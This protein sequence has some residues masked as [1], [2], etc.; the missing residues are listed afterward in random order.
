MRKFDY[1]NNPIK[2]LKPEIVQMVGNI[3]EHKGRQELLR[4]ISVWKNW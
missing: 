2:L 4:V 1:I 3:H